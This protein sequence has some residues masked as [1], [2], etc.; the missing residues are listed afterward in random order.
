[1]EERL[2]EGRRKGREGKVLEWNNWK[3]AKTREK[4]R[5]GRVTDEKGGN[6]C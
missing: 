2:N 4:L 1:M 6:E 3:N 5:E